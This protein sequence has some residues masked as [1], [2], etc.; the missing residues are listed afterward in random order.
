MGPPHFAEA[1]EDFPGEFISR[2]CFLRA[3]PLPPGHEMGFLG[4]GLAK[5]KVGKVKVHLFL[6]LSG[7]PGRKT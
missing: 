2:R 6:E 3:M 7:F 1:R 4:K 5:L